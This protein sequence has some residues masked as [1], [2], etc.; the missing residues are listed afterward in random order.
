MERGHALRLI[1]K[2]KEEIHGTKIVIIGL[3]QR[4]ELALEFIEAG[5]TGYVFR[6]GTLAELVRTIEAVR[7][8]QAPCAPNIVASA[9][10]RINQLSAQQRQGNRPE[11][12]V[13]TQREQDILSLVA[14]G[15]SNKEIARHFSLSLSTVKNHVHNILD[16]LK[17]H[18]RR[19]AVKLTNEN[20]WLI[21]FNSPHPSPNRN[22]LSTSHS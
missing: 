10:A 3:S 2:I 16:K 13:L 22:D 21:N 4:D 1:Q 11:Q 15:L 9:F 6:E 7:R 19:E 8:N 12:V 20:G 17:V 18:H 14:L 5:A